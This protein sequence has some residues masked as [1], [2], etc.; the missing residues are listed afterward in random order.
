[1]SRPVAEVGSTANSYEILAKLATG[2]MAEIFLARGASAAGV[3]RYV[4]LKRVLR[5]RATDVDFVRMFLDEARLA[6]QLQHPNVA[7]VFDV[8]KLGDSYFFTME[9]VHGETVRAL[10]Q[11]AHALRRPIPIATVLTIIAGAAAGLHHAHERIGTDG[12]PL[13]IVHRDVSPSNLMVSYEG[14]VKVVD[15]GVA[16]ATHSTHETR[17]GAVKGKI[18]Y[19]SPEQ[20][21]GTEIDRRSDL[22][23]LGIIMWEMLTTE[24]LFRR[25]TDFAN[26]AAIVNDDALPPSARRP[27]VPPDVDA[28]VLKLLAKAP[29]DRF[30]TADE[31]H[32][33][34]ET[35][36]IRTGSALSGGSLGRLLR[37][38][39]GQR[40]EPWVE[41]QTREAHPEVVTVTSEPLPQSFVLSVSGAV[42]RELE[43]VQDLS[44]V[45]RPPARDSI[46]T[47]PQRA[48]SPEGVPTVAFTR[49][50]PIPTTPFVRA[51]PGPP[52][53]GF[54]TIDLRRKSPSQSPVQSPI[55]SRLPLTADQLPT[56]LIGVAPAPT[57]APPPVS[58]SGPYA[59][60]YSAIQP[61]GSTIVGIHRAGSLSRPNPVPAARAKRIPRVL[62]IL[63]PAIVIGVVI[64]I[65]VAVGGDASVASQ[66][67]RDA[68][69]AIAPSTTPSVAPSG[70]PTVTP[71]ATVDAG[72]LAVAVATPDAAVDAVAPVEVDA[73]VATTTTPPKASPTP[74]LRPSRPPPPNLEELVKAERFA[75]AIA[76]CA[77]TPAIATQNPVRCV[78][79]ACKAHETTK[80]RKWFAMVPVDKRPSLITACKSSGIQ[81]EAAKP[82]TPHPTDTP[83]TDPMACQH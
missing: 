52:S 8:G 34:I 32:E 25:D 2:G 28:L 48:V 50:E 83:C 35:V 13:G 79:A 38:L 51:E 23:S 6:A 11:R 45:G 33:S 74:R 17:S 82:G 26:M 60:S 20:C 40:P 80:A 1:V 5:H 7:Q 18:S 55:I 36:A 77:G 78:F 66:A 57:P 15:F 19:L 63:G 56:P 10:L 76:A 21:R 4:V 64:G 30:Q 81:L 41:M 37:E 59:P 31:L 27:D 44:S 24:R 43:N 70:T 58:A 39:F 53:V 46:P 62:L 16:K 61:M 14:S 54:P 49:P 71:I 65:V 29:A 9:Y 12:R 68:A 73:G 72:E 69:V 67:E 22:F 75:D 47:T 42:E 3:E